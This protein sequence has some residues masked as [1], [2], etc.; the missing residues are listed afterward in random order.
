MLNWG[1][2]IKTT[3][4]LYITKELGSQTGML[5]KLGGYHILKWSAD[6]CHSQSD[7]CIL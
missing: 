6:K 1:L 5:H 2:E 7:T 4:I 3:L